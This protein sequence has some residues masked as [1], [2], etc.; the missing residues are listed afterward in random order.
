MI[1]IFFAAL[2]LW[3]I[4]RQVIVKEDFR[5][6]LNEYSTLLHKPGTWFYI[7]VLLI[8]MLLNWTLE[9]QKWRVLLLKIQKISLL[10]SLR[11]VFS[12]ITISFFTP[13]RIGEY[14]ARVFYLKNVS[15]IKAILATIVGSMNQLLITVIAGTIAL[16]F[17][18]KDS[19]AESRTVYFITA[20]IMSAGIILVCRIYFSV[21]SLYNFLKKLKPLK[22]FDKYIR[23]FT[24]YHG[25][26]LGTIT[27][28]SA[29]RYLVFTLQLTSLLFLF[30]ANTDFFITYRLIAVIFLVMSVVPTFALTELTVRGSIALYFMHPYVENST[31]IVAA[32][33]S[34]WFINLVIP[35]ILG[36]VMI[37]FIRISVKQD[38]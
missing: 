24:Y 14:A 20:A 4:H 37:L 3:I 30:G 2:S 21:P 10:H 18:L 36:A 22:K 25:Q 13:N 12:G 33:F 9:A 8:M 16:I 23:V 17:E 29:I 35:A 32:F 27:I 1:K 38:E 26:E 5:S 7:V 6:T 34:L 11:A 15:R 28:F 31:G 19:F